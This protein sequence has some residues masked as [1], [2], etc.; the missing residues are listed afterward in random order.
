MLVILDGWGLAPAGPGNAISMA[1]TPNF[2][3]LWSHYPHLSLAAS[4]EEV[5]LPAGQIGNSEVGHLNIGAGRV[6]LQDLPRISNSIK[7][8]SFFK[9]KVLADTFTYAKKNNKAVHLLGLVSDGGVHSH[10]SHLLALLE[11]A[12][13]EK[14]HEVYIH[15]FTDGRDVAPK[16]A[17]KY[18]A[19][20]EKEIKAIGVGKIATVCGRYFSMDRDNRWDRVELAYDAIVSGK[21]ELSDTAQEAISDNYA[22]GVT[23]EFVR[24]TVIDPA[25]QIADGDA[26]IFFN[27]RSDR[28]RE[29]SRALIDSKFAGFKRKKTLKELYFVTMTEYDASLAVNGVVFPFEEQ[30]NVLNEVISAEGLKQFHIA[31]TEK[32]AHVTFFL[33]GGREKAVAGEDRVLIPSPKVATYDLKPEMSAAGIGEKLLDAIGR[34]DFIV[35]NFANADMVG[36]TGIVKAAIKAC[37]A[38]DSELGKVVKKGLQLGYN[39]IVTADHGNAEKMLNRDGTP[40]TAHTTSLVPFILASNESHKLRRLAEPRLGNIAPTI[41]DLMEI[42]KPKEMTESSLFLGKS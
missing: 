10:L 7:N 34:Y 28:P 13:A 42:E 29:I 3:F 8:G 41:L 5:G 37:E 24:P 1:N 20:L 38:V 16:S 33:N 27:L 32:Y 15:V 40:C 18:I 12:K 26:V 14:V 19:E 11:Y 31:E 25:G 4:G 2:D 35:V 17:L 22:R 6:V 21:G 36:H 39:V 23:D 9:N 30:K